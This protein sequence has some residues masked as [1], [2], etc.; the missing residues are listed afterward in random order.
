MSITK[1]YLKK[2]AVCKVTF[3][4]PKEMS[5][6]A[7][8]VHVVGDFNGW[9]T[10]A[11]PMKRQKNGD[12]TTTVDLD[13]YKEYQFRYL[14]DEKDWENDLK[15]DKYVPSPYGNSDNSVVVV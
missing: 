2:K 12:F 8:T 14:K 3:R 15:A 13:M 1:Q 7:K 6:P 10:H 11:T 5:G 9:D 4:M